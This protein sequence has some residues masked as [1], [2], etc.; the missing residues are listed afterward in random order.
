[1]A[2]CGVLNLPN[3]DLAIVCGIL[4]ELVPDRPVFV[5]GSRANGRAA[6]RS[7]LDL[8]IGG[9]QPLSLRLR[10]ELADAFDESDLP[11]EVDVVD[12]TSVTD[13]FR[14][15]IVSEWIELSPALR[16]ANEHTLVA[17]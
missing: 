6:R 12:L 4:N 10:S 16:A 5:F 2:E 1:M 3:S 8:A 9:D 15:R 11:I 13:T 17:G 7:D 14:K